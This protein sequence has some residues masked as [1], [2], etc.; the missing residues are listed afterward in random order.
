MVR[1]AGVLG[2]RNKNAAQGMFKALARPRRGA[3]RVHLLEGSNYSMGL[4]GPKNTQA[5]ALKTE[6]IKSVWDGL[7]EPA[8]EACIKKNSENL[9]Q[10]SP[11]ALA[12]VKS[13]GEFILF[14]DMLGIVPLYYV[15]KA[16]EIF[17][18]SEVKMLIGISPEVKEFPSG[19]LYSSAKGWWTP[20]KKSHPVLDFKPDKIAEKLRNILE[21]AI[22]SR[23]SSGKCGAWLS[24]GLDSSAIVGLLS[25]HVKKLH[26]F[27]IGLSDSPDLFFARRAAKYLNTIH[28]ERI[29]TFKDLLAILPEVIC[30]LESFDAPL[31][32]STLT[33]YLLAHF[34]AEY[35]EEV[36]SG[37]GGDELFAGYSYL[38][39]LSRNT[40]ALEVGS[41]PFKLHNT[42]LQRIDRSVVSAGIA[43][44][45][46]FLD[47]N[48]FQY[49]A[50]IPLKFKLYKKQ[51]K[52][53]VEK[54]ILRKALKGILPEEILSR[55]KAKFWE[56]T[57]LGNLFLQYAE[58]IIADEKFVKERNL[59]DNT[60]LRSKEELLYYRIFRQKFGGV[61][62]SFVGRT[63]DILA[64]GECVSGAGE[65]K[66]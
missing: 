31:I 20:P 10:F 5:Y 49:A 58:K 13:S 25:R 12:A 44:H 8:L 27:S 46:P 56:G 38:K 30:R 2:K 35:V 37:E 40:L 62:L 59:P 60:K 23:K 14:R 15:R 43:A 65:A 7:R 55:P 57:G 48:V 45:L 42:A 41:L 61:D 24:G 17:F 22:V 54:W 4:L 63:G 9:I 50:R 19:H 51:G 1:I 21:E 18:A 66:K 32:R 34:S 64:G 39:E 36:F 53:P 6:S 33:N 28:H 3:Y 11:L 47:F 29:V 16:D 26:T 52:A